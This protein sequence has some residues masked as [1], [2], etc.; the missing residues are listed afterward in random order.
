MEKVIAIIGGG[1]TA[2][3]FIHHYVRQADDVGELPRTIY[4]FEKNRAFGPGAAYMADTAS[5]LLNTKTGYITP[6][7]DKPG[8]FQAWLSAKEAFWRMH[9]PHFEIDSNN[10][11]PRPLF[12]L[13]LQDRMAW[14]VG[15]AAA[16]G[17]RIV[18]IHAEVKDISRLN[19]GYV[20]RTDGSLTM[21]AD[22][23]F[24]LC[25][26]LPEKVPE[27]LR[28]NDR[29]LAQPY[30]IA[31][32]PSKIPRATKVAVVGA[33]LSCIDAV[34][35]LIEAGHVGH[36]AIYS[37]S[38]YFPS[39][40]GTQ[41]RIVPRYLTAE[42]VEALLATKGRLTIHD[43]VNLVRSEIAHLSGTELDAVPSLLVPPRPPA[44]L[45]AYLSKEIEAACQDRPWQAVLYST[46][47]IIELLWQAL[48]EED[49]ATFLDRYMS[50]FM[51]FRVSIPIENA[52]KILGYLAS[53]QVSFHAGRFELTV[54]ED[55]RPLLTSNDA[56]QSRR[57]YDY[58]INAKGSPR[59]V[60]QVESDFVAN[61]TRR[62]EITAH[63]FG[64]IQVDPSTYEVFDAS[65]A[66]NTSM[67]AVG[68]LT[69]G[70]FF[71]T[72]ALD[73][74]ARHARLCVQSFA[75]AVK[76]DHLNAHSKSSDQLCYEDAVGL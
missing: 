61:L 20:V 71:F 36:V 63:E 45:R 66:R 46:N 52:Q 16:R 8:D 3:S 4:L 42:G 74:N 56:Q 23:I 24:M 29:V 17:I 55:G 49:K 21:M 30:P 50:P 69:V 47:A 14:L 13:Y 10:Y 37:R 60:H 1:A 31:D 18:Q 32:L 70:T 68:E 7:H 6:F 5:N 12:G 76:Q 25:G 27:A 53:G 73:I 44:C 75:Q 11:A 39:V 58:V 51:S 35:G 9:Y 64:G 62:G 22:Y 54:G 72:S 15:L 57:R 59:S 65:G 41:G 67:R 40:R 48:T 2:L 19:G 43:I 26:T 28:R 34:I 33:R 38:G